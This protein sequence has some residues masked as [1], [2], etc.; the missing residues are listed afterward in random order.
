MVVSVV[1]LFVTTNVMG[2]GHSTSTAQSSA[3]V[4]H[5][6]SIDD[7][8][9]FA[10]PNNKKH[11]VLTIMGL[12]VGD[13]LSMRIDGEIVINNRIYSSEDSL[14]YADINGRMDECFF[15]VYYVNNL[16]RTIYNSR[17][18]SEYTTFKRKKTKNASCEVEFLFNGQSYPFL[19]QLKDRWHIILIGRDTREVYY[20]SKEY[21]RG[22]D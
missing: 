2:Q 20:Y 13:T 21:F 3:N 17:N 5:C 8:W 4:K 1:L 14:Q 15:L 19:F 12:K 10:K 6:H 7:I 22:I 16:L 18:C 11:A 9:K